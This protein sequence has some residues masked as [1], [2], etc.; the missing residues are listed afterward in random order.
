MT[1]EP[2][3]TGAAPI[4]QHCPSK[5][6]MP[7]VIDIRGLVIGSETGVPILRGID[8]TVNPGEHWV[9]LGPNGSGKTTLLGAVTG[10]L[11]DTTGVPSGHIAVLD[12][13]YGEAD[14]RELRKTV[15]LVG[16]G[17]R[18]LI[19]DDNTA[20][21]T[22]AGGQEA[23]LFIWKKLT[24]AVLRHARRCL[25]DAECGHLADRRWGVLSQGERQRVIIARA[26]MAKPRLLILD[27]P[28]AGLDPVARA[29][30]LTFVSRL[31]RAPKAPTLVLVTHHVEEIT[32]DFTHVLM[33][34]AG[35]VL[36]A[37]PL[38]R[39]LTSATLAAAFDAPLRLTGKPG[40]YALK[41][42][43]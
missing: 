17:L 31:A 14:W 8:W 36:A 16:S 33:L 5:L 23:L 18:H 38:D 11:H 13:V 20:L 25:R 2:K 22:V 43:R 3:Q 21:D 40:A 42:A 19:P 30:F 35:R 15:G 32:A 6:P 7:P 34:K 24:P 28:C 39:T 27:E 10:Y 37:G 1:R 4:L 9:I 41:S 26:L 12:S 29:D